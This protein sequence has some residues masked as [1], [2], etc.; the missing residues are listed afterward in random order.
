LDREGFASGEEE[1]ERPTLK[2]QTDSSESDCNPFDVREELQEGFVRSG[3]RN[4][5]V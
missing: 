3:V 1:S 5:S 2:E 4:D